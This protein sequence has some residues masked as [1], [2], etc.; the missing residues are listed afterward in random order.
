MIGE[1]VQQLV[2]ALGSRLRRSVAVDDHMLSLVAVGADYGDSD[3]AR[4]WSLLNRRTR[5]EDVGYSTLR[6]ASGPVRIEE[7]E[8]L[9]LCAR[10]CVPI[11]YEGDLLGFLWIIDR[12]RNLDEEQLAT[13][14]VAAEEMGVELRQRM[15]IRD[16][17]AALA[18]YL[19]DELVSHDAER[20]ARAAGD[21]RQ[22]GFVAT[23]AHVGVLVVEA[24]AGAKQSPATLLDAVQRAGRSHPPGCWV[25]SVTARRATVLVAGARP[26]DGE[27]AAAAQRLQSLLSARVQGWWVA[28]GGPTQGLAGA[29]TSRHQA[30]VTL[31][32]AQRLHGAPAGVEVASWADLGPYRL[33]GQVSTDVLAADCLPIGLFTLLRSGDAGHLLDTVETFLDCAGDK[34]RAAKELDIHRTTLYYRLDR[35]EAITGM[36]LNHGPD[37]LLLHLAV[38]LHRL[39]TAA[40]LVELLDPGRRHLPARVSGEM[41]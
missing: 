29:A 16:R 23:D 17:D 19:L 10:V 26:V 35:I 11:R 8:E 7:N 14:V 3:P 12:D 22:H 41:S 2:D 5:P 21:I 24:D 33:I 28:L 25:Q 20:S 34:Q 32:V 18:S 36:S 37:R 38:K 4:M 39:G 40:Q 1:R 9:G 31:S 30:M 13:A 15:M 27:L 6:T